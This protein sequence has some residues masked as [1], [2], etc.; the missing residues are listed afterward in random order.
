[1]DVY[2][3]LRNEEENGMGMPLPAGRVRVHKKDPVDNQQ[4]F[5]GEDIIDHTPKDEDV[6]LRLGCAFD[7]VGERKQ[8]NFVR[9][10]NRIDETFE[11]TLRNHRN[12][13]VN[14]IVKETLYRWINWE[15]IESRLEYEKQDS[16]T[17]HFSVAVPAGGETK[18]TYTVRYTW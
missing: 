12:E 8:T 9:N 15:I 1:V 7:V 11:I 6:L 18:I 10:G 14:V 3:K 2:L 16:R 5:I 17:I 4:E 13:D